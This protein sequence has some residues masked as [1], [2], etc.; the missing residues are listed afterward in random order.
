[1]SVLGVGG[2]RET[3][4]DVRTGNGNLNLKKRYKDFIEFEI[5][6][7]IKKIV[8]LKLNRI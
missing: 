2:E 7:L 1:M 4:Q 6:K 5:L 3:G 8:C